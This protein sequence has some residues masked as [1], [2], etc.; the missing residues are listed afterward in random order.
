MDGMAGNHLITDEATLVA[1]Y[2]ES[3]PAAL[4][5][6][7]D[8]LHP[9]YCAMIA[10]SPFVVMA[11]SGPGGLDVSPRGDPAGFVTIA[12]DRT[13]LVPDRRGNNR[14]DSLRNLIADPRIA[15]LFMIPGVGETLRVNGRAEIS[16][17][18]ALLA[19]FPM[20]GKLPRSVIVVHVESVYF[21]CPKALVRSELW[22]PAR[23]IERKSL[24]S[25]GTIL[26][27]IS[28]GAAGG[29]EYDRAYPER[30]KAT[31]Y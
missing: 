20:Q 2:G 19:R 15:L 3:S 7:V 18:P 27:D 14:V 22:N 8:Y 13:L 5:K 28:R 30:L 6:E 17:D 24:P 21:Q 10:A 25:T 9:H 12:D 31:I 1:L 23:H 29:D 16:I 11:T 26:A 4:T